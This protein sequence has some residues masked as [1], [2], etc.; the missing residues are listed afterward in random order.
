MSTSAH[1]IPSEADLEPADAT[2]PGAT[3][4]RGLNRA[5][6]VLQALAQT[7]MR[8]VELCKH[9]GLPWTSVHRL[10][11]QLVA[12]RFVEKEP[13]S[14]RYRIGQASWLVG[15]AYTVHHPVLDVARPSLELLAS[16]VDA[17]VQLCERADRLALTLLSVHRSDSESILKT[18]YGYHFPLHC[19]SKG[20]VLLAFSDKD[21]ID[22]YLTKPLEQLTHET[23]TDPGRLREIL[24]EIRE[25]GY[26]RTE[27]D[28]QLFTGSLAAPVFGRD[29]R[30][31][32][33][34]CVIMR[35][36]VL[37]NEGATTSAVERILGV[38]RSISAALSWRPGA[39]QVW[40]DDE[41]IT[42]SAGG[43]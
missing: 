37:A 4:L 22:W 23:I 2:S 40:Q 41:P 42:H 8:P 29:G 6:D 18:T 19:G 25:K 39:D 13:D 24:A 12:Q 9:L 5:L 11:A 38:A 10:I 7:P 3:T 15:G 14:G 21:F 28:V 31:A 33:S 43:S 35:R 1:N 36:S 32:A 26:A 20:Q 27:A 17:V 16:N 34:I 30:A